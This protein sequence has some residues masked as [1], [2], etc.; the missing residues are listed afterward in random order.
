M[1]G[2]QVTVVY[3]VTNITGRNLSL[4]ITGMSDEN[5]KSPRQD[6]A[7]LP[8]QQQILT[9][10]IFWTSSG[11][12]SFTLMGNEPTGQ[13]IIV[14]NNPSDIT[15]GFH[16]VPVYG[17]DV[18]DEAAIIVYDTSTAPLRPI[19]SDI[20]PDEQNNSD[21]DSVNAAGVINA[22]AGGVDALFA[23]SKTSG[24]WKSEE[25]GPWRQLENSPARAYCISANPPDFQNMAVGERDGDSV[26]AHLDQCGVRPNVDRNKWQMMH[27]GASVGLCV[28][29]CVI[30]VSRNRGESGKKRKY[31]THLKY[32]RPCKSIIYKVS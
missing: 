19:W 5:K 13:T 11:N 18:S 14:L 24:V 2:T 16:T 17:P 26:D 8:M 21:F 9:T 28:N 1:I 30:Y 22:I 20:G 10:A 25:G 3:S 6:I 23:V 4:K 15:E 31:M 27:C 12:H 29:P 7:L 32:K